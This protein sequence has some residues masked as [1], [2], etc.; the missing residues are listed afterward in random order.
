M[1]RLLNCTPMCFSNTFRTMATKRY[2]VIY[3]DN[4]RLCVD[5]DF[6]GINATESCLLP[7]NREYVFH[8]ACFNLTV[9]PLAFHI[10]SQLYDFDFG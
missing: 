1:A 9:L 6:G 10:T 2:N 5:F 3:G 4:T 7:T 8:D